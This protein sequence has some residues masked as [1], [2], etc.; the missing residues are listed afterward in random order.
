MLRIVLGGGSVAYSAGELG[1]GSVNSSAGELGDDL[2]L[3]V[4]V[5]QAA[6]DRVPEMV[7]TQP[8]EPCGGGNCVPNHPWVTGRQSDHLGLCGRSMPSHIR[9]VR[10]H[11]I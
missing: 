10:L 5:Q 3:I 7:S 11:E 8:S 4:S 1:D 9:F 6:D 2:L